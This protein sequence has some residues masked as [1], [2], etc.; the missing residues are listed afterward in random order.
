LIGTAPFGRALGALP[1][2]AIASAIL[3]VPVVIGIQAWVHYRFFIQGAGQREANRG[4]SAVPVPAV[5]GG[6]SAV[7]GE[8]SAVP[9]ESE[10]QG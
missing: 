10:T 6:T 3:L 9:A 4:D 1:L 5:P 7:P 8:E 2:L